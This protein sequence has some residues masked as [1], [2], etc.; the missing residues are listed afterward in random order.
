MASEM[1]RAKREMREEKRR[2]EAREVERIGKKGKKHKCCLTRAIR[3]S[4]ER[5]NYDEI[6]VSACIL[7]SRSIVEMLLRLL[8]LFCSLS[9]YLCEHFRLNRFANDRT[10]QRGNEIRRRNENNNKEYHFW[11][12]FFVWSL[13]SRSLATTMSDS[14]DSIP[15]FVVVRNQFN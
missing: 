2:K 4:S 13:H 9:S 14:I 7:N 3:L 12:R 8:S 6:I 5:K 15:H 11:A 1:R 10:E